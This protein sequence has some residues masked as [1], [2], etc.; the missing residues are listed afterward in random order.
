MKLTL[1]EKIIKGDSFS[2]EGDLDSAMT[3]WKIRCEIYDN[4][5]L[6]IRLATLN[7]SGSDDDILITDASAGEFII[8]VGK[9][10]T[11]NFT[12]KGYIEIEVE[13]NDDPTKIYTIYQGEIEFSDEKITWT[14]PSA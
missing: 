13:T 11:T 8:N 6:Y 3:S 7:S 4:G 5:G 9:N 10:L 14:D 1:P 12:D 2:L